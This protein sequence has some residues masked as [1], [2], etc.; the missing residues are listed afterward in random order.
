MSGDSRAGMVRHRHLNHVALIG[1]ACTNGEPQ[2]AGKVRD[3][4]QDDK[5]LQLKV[6]EDMPGLAD[7]QDRTQ[8]IRLNTSFHSFHSFSIIL[9]LP[10][11]CAL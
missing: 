11:G 7:L 3:S 5:D 8:R 9:A 2:A 4:K 10:P 1:V 6:S